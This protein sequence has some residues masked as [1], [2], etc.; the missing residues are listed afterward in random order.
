MGAG[1]S[2][3][4][5]LTIIQTS[6]GLAEYL[7]KVEPNARNAG[8]VIGHDARHNSEKFAGLTAAACIAQGIR[9][10]W[11][12]GLVHTPMVPFAVQ[13]LQTAAG[14][15]ITAS[16]NPAQD[17]GYKV[18]GSNGCQI[19]SPVDQLIAASIMENLEPISWD[20]QRSSPL[21]NPI[22]HSMR[23]IYRS[24]VSAYLLM[25]DTHHIPLFIYTP[26]HGVGLS[27]MKDML[28]ASSTNV[29]STSPGKIS[30]RMELVKEQAD[31]DPEFPTVRFPNPEEGGALDLAKATANRSRCNLII[32]NDPDADRF[33]AAEKVNQEWHQFTG[34]EVGVLLA[35]HIFSKLK[36]KPTEDDIMLLS[37]VSSTNLARIAAHEGFTVVETL[38]GFKW[39]GNEA[40]RLAK[41]G[42]RVHF[43]YEEALGYMFPQIVHDKDGV[44]AAGMFLKACTEWGSP[45]QKLQRLYQRYGYFHTLNTYWRSPD[46]ATT[47]A[48][49]ETMSTKD[50]FGECISASWFFLSHPRPFIISHAFL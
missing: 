35:Y 3:L 22:L 27:Y 17:N 10:L 12:E 48:I 21:L 47:R 46:V 31:P 42:K 23:P 36:N 34:D 38:T 20:F 28:D 41:E 50:L 5:S 37:A 25:K 1:F 39:L 6:Q 44:V 49:F 19:N 16:H 30:Q 33:A 43:A 11:F 4:N 26:M 40:R 14:V 15:M 8:V 29:S 7:I 13:T 9:V 24:G 32:A 2:R 45:Y 18:Y